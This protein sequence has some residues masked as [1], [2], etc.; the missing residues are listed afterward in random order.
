[1]VS[2]AKRIPSR[3]QTRSDSR[4]I[5]LCFCLSWPKAQLVSHTYTWQSALMIILHAL[6]DYCSS[7]TGQTAGEGNLVANINLLRFNNEA[8][9]NY[10]LLVG[11]FRCCQV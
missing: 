3:L 1:M 10:D 8:D 5:L 4:M 6:S 7:A 2:T 11:A 9:I